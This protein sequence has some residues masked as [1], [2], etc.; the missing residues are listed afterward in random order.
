VSRGLPRR[1]IDVLAGY[2]LSAAFSNYDTKAAL[3]LR[4]CGVKMRDFMVKT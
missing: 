3:I 2:F 4:E 1:R